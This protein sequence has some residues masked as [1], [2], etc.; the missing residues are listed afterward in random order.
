MSK[1]VETRVERFGAQMRGLLATQGILAILFGIV[2]L[3]WP[4][5]TVGLLVTFF[6]V[7]ALFW[8][9]MGIVTGLISIGSSKYWWLELIYSVLLLGLAVF[10]LRNP[11][12]AGLVFALLIGVA[13]IVR[14]IVDFVGGIFDRKRD[15]D[16]RLFGIIAGIISVIAGIV[17]WVYPVASGIAVVWVIGLYGIL[18]GALALGFAIR[19]QHNTK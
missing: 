10:V 9:V 6:G 15:E 11:V 5:L 3:F 2:A 18:Y 19:S 12:E 1:D 14:G 13:F 8:A 4:G 7:F 16:S 17:I